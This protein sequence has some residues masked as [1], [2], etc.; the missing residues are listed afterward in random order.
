MTVFLD[1]SALVKRYANEPG[2]DLVQAV[3]EPMIASDLAAVEVP[4]ALWRKHRVGEISATDAQVLCWRFL[5]DISASTR[6]SDT[7]LIGV[8]EDILRS[9][10]DLVARHPLRAYDAVQLA[11]ALAASR[12]IGRC[13]FGCF[14]EQLTDAAVAEGLMLLW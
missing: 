6:D 11:S 14:D 3:S 2:S 5:T 12:L 4:A 9:A 13:P 1:S 7:V 10:I 8:G